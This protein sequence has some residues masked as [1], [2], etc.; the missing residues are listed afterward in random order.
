MTDSVFK[1]MCDEL[2]GKEDKTSVIE[3]GKNYLAS[4]TDPGD[5][6]DSIF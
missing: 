6:D 5:D 1:E 4:G 3:Y 2:A